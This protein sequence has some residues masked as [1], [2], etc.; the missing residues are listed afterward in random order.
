MNIVITGVGKG[1]GYEL[2][3]ILSKEHN[4]LGISRNTS[5]LASNEKLLT[6]SLDLTKEESISTIE[7]FI[8]SQF[9]NIDIL[10]NNAG[11][12]VN[13]PFAQLEFS[14]INNMIEVNLMAPFKITQCL[15]PFMK[16]G[17]HIVNI[18]SMGGFQGSVKFPG[19]SFYSASKGALAVLTECLAEELKEQGIQVNCLAL[20]AAQTEMLSNAFP[21]FKAPLSAFEMAQHIADFA[22]HGNQYFNGKI[23]P[24][25]VSTP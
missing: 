8:I 22:L 14:E 25:S 9:K 15:I 12:L 10:I 16:K 23:L 19:L 6:L 4:V 13:K 5:H 2:T 20:G 1:I 18:G 24:V 3:K 11:I 7:Q 17:S 21:G